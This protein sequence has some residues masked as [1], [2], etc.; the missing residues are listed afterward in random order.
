MSRP[1]LHLLHVLTA[2]LVVM[3]TVAVTPAGADVPT[4]ATGTPAIGRTS[5]AA[6]TTLLG[7]GDVVGSGTRQTPRADGRSFADQAFPVP[8]PVWGERTLDGLTVTAVDAAERMSCALASGKVFCWGRTRSPGDGR[9]H[10][11]GIGLPVRVGGALIGRPVTAIAVG[12][13]HACALTGD[14]VYCWG[15]NSRG[16]LGRGTIGGGAATPVV[17]LLGSAVPRVDAIDAGDDHT[18][19]TSAGA[20]RCW[21]ANDHGQLG[22]GTQTDRG[23]P[24]LAGG[25]LVGRSVTAMSAGGR[26]TCALADNWSH[27]WGVVEWDLAGTPMATTSP[28][29]T[30]VPEELPRP[31]FASIGVGGGTV[32][33][34]TV[35]GAAW[36]W[37]LDNR[38]Q[39]GGQSRWVHDPT[40]GPVVTDGV[41]A[42]RTVSQLRVGATH[43]CALAS[44]RMICWGDRSRG[45][46]GS[47]TTGGRSAPAEVY[48]DG[49][50]AGRSVIGI[51]AGDGV[52]FAIT[53]GAPGQVAAPGALQLVRPVRVLDTRTTAGTGIP[54]GGTKKVRVAGIG[55]V[56][57]AVSAVA[58]GVTVAEPAASGYLQ[59]YPSGSTIP[60]MATTNFTTQAGTVS[61]LVITPV[62]ADGTVTLRNVSSR[63]VQVFVDISGYFLPGAARTPGALVPLRPVRA[64]DIYVAAGEMFEWR[65][66]G[67][68]GLPAS[69]GSV[70][71]NWTVVGAD[72][73]GTFESRTTVV[74]A[75][76]SGS[77]MI[78]NWSPRRV[79][80]I[81]DVQGRFVP[82]VPSA[83]GTYH[84][85][86]EAMD[87][88]T[89]PLPANARIPIPA[90]AVDDTVG[91]YAP[92]YGAVLGTLSAAAGTGY[93][94]VQPPSVVGAPT[95]TL[96]SGKRHSTTTFL[97]AADAVLVNRTG[98]QVAYE[99]SE[100]GYFLR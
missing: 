21:G 43:V 17:A 50:L 6:P 37:G 90:V 30:R 84:A 96:K 28:T 64:V 75:D 42:G 59:V 20:V 5:A 85:G 60:G 51:G 9:P 53:T 67:T 32:C 82:G 4:G 70:L 35:G 54:A 80:L 16:Q 18:C 31:D 39:T 55:G 44:G 58:F 47:G 11:Y 48:T 76:E 92:Q 62:D 56:P 41:L 29:A 69:V 63:T 98:R 99:L 78:A 8:S 88:R 89:T 68:V 12:R 26:T 52:S 19:V 61:Q 3:G 7:W 94:T 87:S 24:V 22:D 38:G 81:L 86:G 91:G 100:Q 66:G 45:A 57:A 83:A 73:P 15:D 27:C 79:R 10:P 74:T 93:L 25:T 2:L 23:S 13:D 36:C 34:V 49:A 97:A 40:P 95:A 65:P 14:R 71:V 72:G 33:A 46:I 1:R 77:V